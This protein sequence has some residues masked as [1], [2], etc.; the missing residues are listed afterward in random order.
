MEENGEARW[1]AKVEDSK[2]QEKVGPEEKQ[3]M[4]EK[5]EEKVETRV[6]RA[7]KGQWVDVSNAEG[8]TSPVSAHIDG[9][10]APTTSAIGGP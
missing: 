1:G 5:V 2:E 7:E 3:A 4:G 9:R 8:L 10:V 6:E